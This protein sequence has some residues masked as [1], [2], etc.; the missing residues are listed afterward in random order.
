MKRFDSPVTASLTSR[1]HGFA[2]AAEPTADR[3]PVFARQ[4][5]VENDEMRRVALQF[6]VDVAC[7]GQRGDVEALLGQITR[8]QVA[9]PY[10]IVDDEDLGGGVA[11]GHGELDDCPQAAC[12]ATCNQL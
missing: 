4:H 2:G 8:Q 1:R 10:V 5:Q 3:K 11:C 9:Q 6:L 7:V 12:S